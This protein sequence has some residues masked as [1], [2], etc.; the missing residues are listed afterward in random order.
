MA[1][2]FSS[3]R[4]SVSQF[5]NRSGHHVKFVKTFTK[6]SG[7]YDKLPF[8]FS[9]DDC[10]SVNKNKEQKIKRVTD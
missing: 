9:D 4:H 6:S 7:P 8:V 10:A 2:A 5:F 3:L 1:P